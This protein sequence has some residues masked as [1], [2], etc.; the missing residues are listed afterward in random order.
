[1][2]LVFIVHGWILSDR[3]RI[4]STC[5]ISLYYLNKNIHFNKLILELPFGW[6][7]RKERRKSQNLRYWKMYASSSYRENR[8]TSLVL[9]H[10]DLT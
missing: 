6:G 3:P 10:Y 2:S 9:H 7:G 8:P 5:R 4:F 1:M